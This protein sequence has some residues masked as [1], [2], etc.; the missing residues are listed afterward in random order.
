M[1]PIPLDDSKIDSLPGRSIIEHAIEFATIAHKEQTRKGTNIPYIIH[2]YIVGMTLQQAGCSDEI[3][4]AGILHDVIEDTPVNLE[5]LTSEFGK[6]VA[7]LVMQCSEPDRSLPWEERKK[8]TI[9]FLCTAPLAVKFITAA[10]K[11]HNI[12]SVAYDELQEGEKVWERFSRGKEKQ[13]WY[14]SGIIK[15]LFYHLPDNAD[16]SIFMELKSEVQ[17]VFG[18]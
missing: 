5:N 7:G 2:P 11:L 14:Y 15:S 12:R 17:R 6:D 8:H 3:I 1:S 18:N 4:A 13:E 9:N 10:D 16:H